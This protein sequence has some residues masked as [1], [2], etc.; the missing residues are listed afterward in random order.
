MKKIKMTAICLSTAIALS[1]FTPLVLAHAD[2]GKAKGK[3]KNQIA[4]N[5]T[6]KIAPGQIKFMF[7]DS[8]QYKDIFSWAL[9]SIEKLGAKGIISGYGDR[10]FRPQNKVTNLEA[11]TLILKLTDYKE[12]AEK[13]D[14]I[15]SSLAKYQKQWGIKWGWG[16]LYVAVE[17][18]ILLPEEIKDFNPNQPIKRHELAK[19]LVRAMGLTKEAEKH[20]NSKLDFKDANAIPKDSRGYVHVINELGIMTGNENKQFK[21]NEPLTRAEIAVCI[22]R[23]EDYLNGD[24]YENENEAKVIFQ[25]YIDDKLTVKQNGKTVSYKTINDVIVYKDKEYTNIDSLEKGDVLEIVLNNSK[26]VIFIEVIGEVEDKNQSKYDNRE[27]VKFSS[28]NYNKLPDAIKNKIDVKRV[29]KGYE[30]YE[31][32]DE[33]YLVAY[34]GKKNTGGYSIEIENVERYKVNSNYIIEA[35][36]V[37]TAPDKN[38]ISTQALTYPYD[39]VKLNKFDKLSRVYFA[40]EKGNIIARK[41]IEN[42]DE[43]TTATGYFSKIDDDCIYIK[44]KSGSA[45]SKYELSENVQVYINNKEKELEDLKEGMKVSLTIIYDY[46]EKISADYDAKKAEGTIQFV[47]ESKN[48]IRLKHDNKLTTYSLADDVKILVD[49]IESR[50]SDLQFGMKTELEL[51][52]NKVIKIEAVNY[53][54]SYQGKIKDI[55]ISQNKVKC[56]TLLIDNSRVK[57]D[58]TEDTSFHMLDEDADPSN[59]AINSLIKVNLING[60]VIEVIEIK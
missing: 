8:E 2:N 28:V 3:E 36:V 48:Q 9:K 4:N 33:I 1:S 51:L 59:L 19:Y 53:E 41:P 21:P 18:G 13:N 38:T 32:D 27:D 37:E 20:M 30:A 12:D 5:M 6:I 55:D 34:M 24:I 14:K 56:I 60:K 29:S 31:Y 11:L 16:Y 49:G 17:E 58:I 52:N 15:H 50:L 47:D 43:T 46:V 10:S 26:Q 39:V 54:E 7:S 45:F 22:D 44:A 35:T 57:F 23:A 40:D 42:I 25:S